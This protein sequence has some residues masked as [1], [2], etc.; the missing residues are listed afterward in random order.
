MGHP[1]PR[2]GIATDEVYNEF[3]TALKRSNFT[4]I[5]ILDELDQLLSNGM[6]STILYDLLRVVEFQKSTLGVVIIANDPNLT[7]KLDPRVRSSLLHSPIEF[8]SYGPQQLKEILRER[9]KY[10]FMDNVVEPDVINLAAAHASKNNGD[11]RL[12]I[13]SLLRAGRIAERAGKEK[14]LVEHL[15]EA[16]DSIHSRVLDKAKD[17]L[18]LEEK[19]ILKILSKESELTSGKLFEFFSKKSKLSNRTFR[20]KLSHLEQMK[21]IEM[22]PLEEGVRGKTRLIRLAQGKK[23]IENVLK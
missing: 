2:R 6:A 19:E 16:F 7:A 10:A 22:K 20:K 1:V 4:P 12:A 17:F 11:A 8:V 21:L 5:V 18:E 9:A 23:E 13:E 14:V 15:R 3:L